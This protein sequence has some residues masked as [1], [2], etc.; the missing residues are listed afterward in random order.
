MPTQ[1]GT[2]RWI[3]EADDSQFN[4]T[5]DN[6]EKRAETT[7]RVLKKNDIGSS[8]WSS[9]SRGAKDTASVMGELGNSI[10][11]LGWEGAKIGATA[12]STALVGL[13]SKGIEGADA[14]AKYNAQI[15]GLAKS[16]A[17]ANSAMSTAVDF[18]KNSFFNLHK[19]LCFV[20]PTNIIS[21]ASSQM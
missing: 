15:V 1:G 12:L 13:T 7:V 14:L 3:I 21:S 6:V 9:I 16:T 19:L 17:D 5:L 18:F 2:V 4:Q 11:S 8:F 20:T 10:A